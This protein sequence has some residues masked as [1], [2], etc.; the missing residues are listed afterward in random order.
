VTDRFSPNCRRA[1]AASEREARSLKHAQIATEHVLLGLLRVE[2]SV[3]AQALRL[4]GVT[5]RKGRRRIMRL[6]DAGAE[7]VDAR[8]SFTPRVREIIE[9][10][11]SGA[12][13]VPR[14]VATSVEGR[15]S[16]PPSR[17][18]L[19]RRSDQRVRSE[20]LLFALLAHG[21]GVAARVLGEVDVDLERLAVAIQQVRFPDL[22]RQALLEQRS[23]PPLAPPDSN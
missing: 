5:H 20:Q 22:T 15:E 1:L 3:A 21:E 23:W 9:D 8:L 18:P 11:F 19:L 12:V 14:V 4:L 17:A 6:V 16:P 13:W 10:A 2:E 7:P